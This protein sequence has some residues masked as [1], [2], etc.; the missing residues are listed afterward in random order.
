M[1]QEKRE[2]NIVLGIRPIIE[3]IKAGKEVDKIL[4]QKNADG[5]LM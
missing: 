1:H 3:A 4:I 2:S 5:D